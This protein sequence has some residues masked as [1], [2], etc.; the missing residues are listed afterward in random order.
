MTFLNYVSVRDIE[1]T[2][3]FRNTFGWLVGLSY[4]A[5]KLLFHLC[6]QWNLQIMDTL[7]LANFDV[8]LLL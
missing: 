5:A 1:L 7:G 8:I 4:K 3:N 6:V 2:E